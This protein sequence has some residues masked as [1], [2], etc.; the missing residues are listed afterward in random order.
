MTSIEDF[1][2]RSKKMVERYA[3]GEP[4]RWTMEGTTLE[5]MTEVGDLTDYILRK[6]YYKPN[7]YQE[8]DYHI[9]DELCDIMF[10]LFRIA[11]AYKI[12]LSEAYQKMLDLM[13]ERLSSK[14]L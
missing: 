14:G 11:D 8:L 5:L 9:E 4:K 3:K 2:K 10:V 13:E 1:A 6:E 12:D 7:V